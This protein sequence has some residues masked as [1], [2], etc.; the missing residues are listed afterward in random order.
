M[1]VFTVH[2]FSHLF[3]MCSPSVQHP[4][5]KSSW[6]ESYGWLKHRFET[7]NSLKI[8]IFSWVYMG[9]NQNRDSTFHH[10]HC[11]RIHTLISPR[12]L[13]SRPPASKQRGPL[14]PKWFG[15]QHSRKWAAGSPENEGSKRGSLGNHEFLGF[16]VSFRK[17]TSNMLHLH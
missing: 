16:H 5:L 15:L 14:S 12:Y 17:Y 9:I 4:L 6:K 1:S 13:S 10:F 3:T 11:L 8:G 2:I 7:K